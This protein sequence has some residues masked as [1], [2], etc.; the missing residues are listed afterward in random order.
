MNSRNQDRKT[1]K[2]MRSLGGKKKKA[3]K[4]EKKKEAEKK[5][6]DEGESDTMEEDTEVRGE[7]RGRETATNED[8]SPL[9]KK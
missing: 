3:R 8:L 5:K 1:R 2:D 6:A 4:Q 9:P 7:K